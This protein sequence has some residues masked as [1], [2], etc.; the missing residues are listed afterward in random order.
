MAEA[1]T[2]TGGVTVYHDR[3]LELPGEIARSTDP[4]ER[5]GRAGHSIRAGSPCQKRELPIALAVIRQ[6]ASRAWGLWQSDTAVAALTNPATL[7]GVVNSFVAPAGTVLHPTVL[8][9]DANRES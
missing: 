6:I 7:S 5:P 9:R 4:V 8:H 2:R 1:W 3:G